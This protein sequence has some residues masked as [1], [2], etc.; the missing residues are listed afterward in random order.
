MLSLGPCEKMKGY[1]ISIT[2]GHPKHHNG[3][4]VFGFY[5]CRYIS[6]ILSK[7]TAVLWIHR[8]ILAEICW[9]GCLS[10]FKN[11]VAWSFF[12]SFMAY[13]KRIALSHLLWEIQNVFMYYLPDKKLR[14]F[15]VLGNG[16]DWLAGIVVSHG[17]DL[18]NT[19]W[20]YFQIRIKLLRCC[21]IVITIGFP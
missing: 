11:F 8:L 17:L 16:P 7:P 15:Y 21:T 12:L 5:C 1:T 18:S 10:L 2:C 14:H 4:K 6:W 3:D 9:S 19:F 13:D 20:N